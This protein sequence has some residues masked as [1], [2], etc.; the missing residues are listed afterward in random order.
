MDKTTKTKIILIA[1]VI[2]FALLVFLGVSALSTKKPKDNNSDQEVSLRADGK[3]E[4]TT[5]DMMKAQEDKTS[6]ENTQTSSSDYSSVS[7]S[8]SSSVP[9]YHGDNSE[10]QELQRQLRENQKTQTQD[11]SS[12]EPAPA[13]STPKYKK[14]KTIKTYAAK[15]VSMEQPTVAVI[16]EPTPKPK[17]NT[18]PNGRSRNLTTPKQAVTNNLISAVIHNDQVITSGAKVKLRIVESI[19]VDGVT[20]PTNSFVFG[21]ATFSKAR[22]NIT[23]SSIIVG[24]SIIPFN[25]SVYDKDGMEGIYLPENV[26]SEDAKEATNDMSSEALNAVNSAGIVGAALNT[27]KNIFRRKAQRQTVTLKANY[28]LFLK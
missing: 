6:Y 14:P 23:L 28:K 9:A 16:P 5:E 13:P 22:M 21:I 4:F 12:S 7:T 8:T 27:G 1:G 15:E 11:E 17:V 26:K 24:S 25:K 2:I 19:V 18:N 10:V 3:N 20:I